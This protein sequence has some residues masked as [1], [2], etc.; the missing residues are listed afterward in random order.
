MLGVAFFCTQH[1]FTSPAVVITS[2]V[3]SSNRNLCVRNMLVWARAFLNPYKGAA[4]IAKYHPTYSYVCIH[5]VAGAWGV[6]IVML[7]T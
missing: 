4:A 7:R 3:P 2:S 1:R 6:S 5:N